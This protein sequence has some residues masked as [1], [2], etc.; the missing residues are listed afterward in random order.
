MMKN[1]TLIGMLLVMLTALLN[2]TAQ[3]GGYGYGGGL[4][5]WVWTWRIS[6][7]VWV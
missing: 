5:T 7:W 2:V 6:R 3:A 1:I 4:R